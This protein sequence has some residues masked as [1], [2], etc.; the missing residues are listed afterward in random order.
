MLS[1]ILVVLTTLLVFCLAGQAQDKAEKADKPTQAKMVS[2][3]FATALY[4]DKD[5]PGVMKLVGVPFL[6]PYGDSS[7]PVKMVD[8]LKKKIETLL[9]QHEA[10]KGTIK[11]YGTAAYEELPGEKPADPAWNKVL[12][13]SDQV[14]GLSIKQEGAEGISLYVMVAWPDDRPSVVGFVIVPPSALE[15]LQKKK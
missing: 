3:Q 2:E 5:V 1:R 8:D 6:W 13:K 14:V 12:K 9:S 10:L 4:L 15:A 11:I 7:G